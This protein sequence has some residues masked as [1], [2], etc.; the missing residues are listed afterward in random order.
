MFFRNNPGDSGRFI[1][2][3][4]VFTVDPEMGLNIGTYRCEIKGPRN[5]AV[6]SGEG[7]SGYNML[8]AAKAR[9]EKS[10]NIALVVGQDPMIWLVSGARI[11]E[12][13]GKKP[14]DELATAGGLRGKAIEVVTCE[15]SDFRVPAHAEITPK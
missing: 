9:G 3:A 7:Q 12:R 15:S 10:A 8:M 11:P 4:S 2:T 6:G 13:R 14:I 5:I 1:N